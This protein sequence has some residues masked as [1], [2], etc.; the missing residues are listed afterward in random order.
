MSE[1]SQIHNS[2]DTLNV[3]HAISELVNTGLSKDSLKI[4]ME[5]LEHGV[6]SLALAEAIKAIRKGVEKKESE[7]EDSQSANGDSGQPSPVTCR[8]LF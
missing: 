4:C 8:K 5:L 2:E 1:N 3:L 7:E 6:S